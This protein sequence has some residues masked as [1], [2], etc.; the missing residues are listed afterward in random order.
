M[1]PEGCED[2]CFWTTVPWGSCAKAVCSR[3]SQL[4]H[5][6]GWQG[7]Q[8]NCDCPSQL[9]KVNSPNF[10]TLKTIENFTCLSIWQLKII[11]NSVGL[12]TG[13]VQDAWKVWG[14]KIMDVSWAASF[15]DLSACDSK[16]KVYRQQNIAELY[17]LTWS[18]YCVHSRVEVYLTSFGKRYTAL[19]CNVNESFWF[20]KYCVSVIINVSQLPDSLPRAGKFV[21]S[22]L[23]FSCRN[24]HTS[25]EGEFSFRHV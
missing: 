9:R 2:G 20:G 23:T 1:R 15:P 6:V 4:E 25:Q 17:C 3:L 11:R 16:S 24:Q 10:Q 12:K 22:I 7:I 5:V 13:L 14:L 19:L 8:Y 18:L 21:R